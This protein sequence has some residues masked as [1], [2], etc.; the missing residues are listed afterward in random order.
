M[1]NSS[2]NIP[3][4]IIEE[5]K[6][7]YKSLFNNYSPNI[8]TKYINNITGEYESNFVCLKRNVIWII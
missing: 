8:Y 7:S 6:E 5:D 2:S 1:Y 4:E 3:H